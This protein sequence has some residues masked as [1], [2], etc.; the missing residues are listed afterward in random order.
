V[1]PPDRCSWWLG[2]AL[3]A[4]AALPAS[5][6][7][8]GRERGERIRIAPGLEADFSVNNVPYDGRVTFVR[9]RYTPERMGY[10]GGGGYFGGINYQWDH[11]YPRADTHLMTML[12]ELTTFAT[13]TTGT[14]ILA[15]DDPELMKHPVAYLVEAGFWTMT[16]DEVVHLRNY[17]L[18]GG[19]LIFDDFIGPYPWYNLTRQLQRV[20]P[21]GRPVQL[22]ASHPIFHSFFEINELNHRHPYAGTPSQFWGIFEDNDPAKRLLMIINRDNDI[23]E[24]WEWSDSGY[25]PIDL[26]DEA[27]KL[28]V[29]YMVYA[30]T[31]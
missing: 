27:Y 9:L 14:D 24:S 7:R 4:L 31:H 8:R 6:Q 28:G 18:K 20:L 3:L 25:I 2:V 12:R 15:V 17:L 10:G 22:D 11:D 29:N 16:D 5:A 19:F 26:S 30:A 21:D 1:R 23:G 13:N